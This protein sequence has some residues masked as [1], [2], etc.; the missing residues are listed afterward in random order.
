[1]LFIENYRHAQMLECCGFI[2]G[3]LIKLIFFAYSVCLIEIFFIFVNH[4]KTLIVNINFAIVE[5]LG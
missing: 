3:L 1:M 5:L 2:G 4:A